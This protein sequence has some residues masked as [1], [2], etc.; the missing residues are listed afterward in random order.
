MAVLNMEELIDGSHGADNEGSLNESNFCRLPHG[1][2]TK[3]SGSQRFGVRYLGSMPPDAESIAHCHACGGVI[4]VSKLA[5][6]SKAKCPACGETTRVKVEFGPYILHHRHAIGGMSVVFIARDKTLGREVAV[7]ILNEDYSAD[8]RRITAFEEEARTTASIS[9]PHVVR[10]LTTGRAFG[11]YYLAMELVTGGNFEIEIRDRGALPETEVLPLALQVAEGLQAAHTAGLIHRDMK[12]GNILLDGTGQAK[13]VDFGLALM[14]K[15]GKAQ[16]SEI[17]ATSYYVPP[18]TVEGWEED[19]RSDIY[20]FGATLYHALSGVPPCNTESHDTKTLREAKKKIAP[21]AEAA[22][23]L[24]PETCVVIDRAMAYKPSDRYQSYDEMIFALRQAQQRSLS[25]PQIE[26]AGAVHRRQ[27]R[28]A[29]RKEALIL[30]GSALLLIGA[31]VSAVYFVKSRPTEAVATVRPSPVVEATVRSD[32]GPQTIDPA[33]ASRI[34]QRYKAAREAVEKGEF[35]QALTEFAALRDDPVVQEPTRTWAGLEAIAAG[36]LGD[37]GDAARS[38]AKLTAAH[39]SSVE[40]INPNVSGVILPAL[41]LVQELPSIPVGALDPI[42][43]DAPTVM[44]WIISGLKNWQQ[45]SLDE[46][47]QFFSAATEVK[48]STADQWASYYQNV[49]ADYL[50]DYA[51][52]QAAEPKHMP[53]DKAGCLDKIAELD[54]VITS[55]VT[56]GRARFNVREW[57]LELRRHVRYLEAEKE[58]S[59]AAAPLSLVGARPEIDRLCSEFKFEETIALLGSFTP[60]EE[61]VAAR[62]AWLEVIGMAA[63]FLS[64]LE[65]DLKQGEVWV[66]LKSRDGSASYLKISDGKDG[67]LKVFDPMGT[68]HLLEWKD[69]APDSIIELYAT[70]TRNLPSDSIKLRRQ[71]SAIVFDWIGGDRK[72]ATAAV[73]RLAVENPAFKTRWEKIAGYFK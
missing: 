47:A 4:D 43:A 48:L 39:A 68:V 51:S 28:T 18:E 25:G 27:V 54:E 16:A 7:K 32:D 37:K 6:F 46:A 8:E 31:I 20:A 12:P 55:L 10:L 56:Q 40:F 41:T 21:L 34:G 53:A 69:L 63:E 9:H 57:Q 14:T 73:D 70:L 26:N 33:I 11:R 64:D 35:E 52:L 61:E 44:A 29:Q 67:K 19:F 3:V 24:A 17:W 58:S 5:P 49:A 23:W 36:F 2:P 38:Q 72:R 22:P 71:E 45:G 65:A 1:F 50:A 30:A 15:G 42:R 13:I 59:E 62:D 60:L 66:E